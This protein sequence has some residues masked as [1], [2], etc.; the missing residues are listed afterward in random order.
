[1]LH[2]AAARR[3]VLS[4]LLVAYGVPAVLV[5]A[6]APGGVDPAPAGFDLNVGVGTRFTTDPGLASDDEGADGDS[7]TDLRAE[8][9]GHRRS[10]RTDWSVRYSPFYTRYRSNSQ[11]DS[12]N[13]AL[14]LDGRYVVTPLSRLSLLE[15]FFYSQDLLQIDAA[16]S[17]GEATIL[18]SQSNRWRNFTDAAFDASLSRSLTLQV[19]ASTRIE[20]FDLD[21]LVNSEMYSGRC[22]IKKQVGR[23][24]SISSTYSYSRFD[25]QGDGLAGA[26]AQGVDLSWSHGSA[27]RTEWALSAGVSKVSQ[28]R[29]RENR[30]TAAASLHH[31]FRRYDFISA[32]RRS[33][34]ADSG[35][36]NVT[37]V[38]D[39]H[40]GISRRLGGRA[41]LTVRGEYGTRDSVLESGDRLALDY[42]G[43][44]I[45]AAIR[46]NPRLSIAGEARRRRQD[47][48][49]GAGEDLT[50]D[51]FFLR[52]DFRIF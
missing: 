47:V 15:R 5:R 29:D 2:P 38:Q 25:F 19:G 16:E 30:L 42:A 50:V 35:V 49:A 20:R 36:A 8:L 31:P 24:G 1:M 3:R 41:S 17:A 37:V 45:Q 14:N 28:G 51:T 27:E 6:Q 39:A 7:I 43:G 4:L 33:L 18:T 9:I 26:E 44:A 23:E 34:G 10:P 22:G 12:I 48:T 32:F 11:L 13:H 21:P 46:L 40:A 52:L